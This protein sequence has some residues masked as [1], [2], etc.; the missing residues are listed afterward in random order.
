LFRA[1]FSLLLLSALSYGQGA[2]LTREKADEILSELRQIRRL[3]AG[4]E[5]GQAA[6]QPPVPRLSLEIGDALVLGSA[7]APLTI[8]EFTD[9]QCPFCQRFHLAT[10]SLLKRDYIDSGKVRFVSRDLPL[11]EVHPYA[12]RAAQAARCAGDQGQFWALR[13]RMQRSTGALDLPNL[14]AHA[15]ELRLDAA[16]FR[17]CVESEKYRSAVENDARVAGKLGVTGTPSFLIGK[18]TPA[19]VEGEIVTGALPYD[20]FSAKLKALLKM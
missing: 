18:S 11:T 16:R 1:L 4:Q 10:F 15:A 20:A 3:L 9:Y 6:Q 13:D 14:I 2:G 17:S 5:T 19:G 7:E 12:L 8:I